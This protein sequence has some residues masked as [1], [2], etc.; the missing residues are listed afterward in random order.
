MEYAQIISVMTL[1]FPN[2]QSEL[3]SCFILSKRLVDD[4]KEDRAA[5]F[6]LDK[7]ELYEFLTRL[8]R[9]I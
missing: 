3:H 7:N 5:H 4:D 2:M 6:T 9:A 8:S 1:I